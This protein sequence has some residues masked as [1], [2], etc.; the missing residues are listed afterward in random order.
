MFVAVLITDWTN[1]RR[2]HRVPVR[3][4]VPEG[5][6]R[7]HYVDAF[8]VRRQPGDVRSAEAIARAALEDAPRPA[9]VIV[10]IVWAVL[11]F[12]VGPARSPAHILGWRI[13]RSHAAMAE[14]AG[15]GP[16]AVARIVVRESEGEVVTTTFLLWR[17]PISRFA[18]VFVSPAHRLMVRFLM[19]RAAVA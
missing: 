5:L 15:D 2:T 3:E 9:R 18:W 8:A 14:I 13:L 16:R 1:E 7:P 10:R 6:D 19:D 17:A 11:G 4:S 12:R